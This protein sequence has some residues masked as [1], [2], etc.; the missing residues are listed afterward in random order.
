[1]L[2]SLVWSVSTPAAFQVTTRRIQWELKHLLHSLILMYVDDIISVCFAKDI[3]CTRLLGPAAAADDKTETGPEFTFSGY[4]VDLTTQR[5]TIAKNNFLNTIYGF[6]EV[7]LTAAISL[8][9]AQRFASWCSRY[10]KICRVLRPF[11]GALHGV[12]AG[13]TSHHATFLLSEEAKLA[14]RCWRAMQAL[15]Y[16][17][18]T[19][20]SRTIESFGNSPPYNVI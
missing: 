4:T 13:R 1:M 3:V 2:D 6:L 14:I 20:F 16:F 7:D 8:K 15:I 12:A 18:E 19:R 11:V 17:N 10:G 9:E 5:V